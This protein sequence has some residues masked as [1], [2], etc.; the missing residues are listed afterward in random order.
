MNV[1]NVKRCVVDSLNLIEAEVSASF[2]S[3]GDQQ[4]NCLVYLFQLQVYVHSVE[5]N[6]VIAVLGAEEINHGFT[7]LDIGLI[8]SIIGHD[9]QDLKHVNLIIDLEPIDLILRH[10]F[11]Y[12]VLLSQWQCIWSLLDAS[13]LVSYPECPL[14]YT[15]F[16]L[17]LE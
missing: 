15:T 1:L 2:G 12:F 7:C 10:D 13:R 16:S 17:H 4:L 14:C 6:S 8:W 11:F 3:L 5:G 9:L